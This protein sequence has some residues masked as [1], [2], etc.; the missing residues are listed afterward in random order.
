MDALIHYIHSYTG[1]C[2]YAIISIVMGSRPGY[3]SL[4]TEQCM[5]FPNG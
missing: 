5:Q 4:N 2:T 3:L 1:A